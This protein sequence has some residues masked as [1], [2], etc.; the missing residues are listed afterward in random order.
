MLVYGKIETTHDA[1]AL[2][3][4][5]VATLEAL[6]DAPSG[7]DR[8]ARLAGAFVDAAALTCA[9]IDRDGMSDMAPL[10][11]LARALDASWRSEAHD[12][13][14]AIAGF[15]ALPATGMI[16]LKPTEGY[17]FYALYPES[18]AE[19]ARRA[20]LPPT[21]RVIGIRSIGTGLA[22]IV[23]AALGAEA[24]L[25]VRPTGHP[26]DRRIEP[27]PELLAGDPPAFAIVDEGPGLSGSSFLSV[28][29]WLMD[30][31]VPCTRIH[32]FPSHHNGPGAEAGVDR[33]KLWRQL[34]QH[35][36]DFAP[37][38]T[39]LP[40]WI[41]TRIGPLTA[42]LR[43]LSGGQWREVTGSIA[44]TAPGAE[45]RKYLAETASGGWMVKFA[46]IG[47]TG[48][49]KLALAQNVSAAGLAPEPAGLA[50]GFLIQRWVDAP[51][52]TQAPLP[53]C[54]LIT[55]LAAY[56]AHRA[57]LT[58]PAD[59]GARPDALAKMAA[60]NTAE[61]LGETAANAMRHR[62]ELNRPSGSPRR[63]WVDARLHPW[64]WLN[65]DGRLIKADALDHAMAHDFIGAQ[66]IEWDLA[67]AI[68]EHDLAPE[69]LLTAYEAAAGPAVDPSLLD[70][71]TGCYL[72]FQLGLWTML[73][74]GPAPATRYREKL[75]VWLG[76]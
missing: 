18:Y 13:R 31:G 36:A 54:R 29:T 25:T 52:L 58:A 42:P 7:L 60:Y 44:P 9:I 10:T 6:C 37:I 30:R 50:H 72:S 38:A 46:G 4:E 64:E 24:P 63:V 62:L 14:P 43:D 74:S 35:V 28:A 1:A 40:G 5:V 71:L 17:A 26:F 15:A 68:I 67:G 34:P 73:G 45:R 21:T 39:R 8:H 57:T 51:N 16:R 49:R 69:P 22:A 2:H 3:A 59:A 76:R 55:Q 19:A 48:H 11:A 47:A 65:A 75:S 20:G 33:L 56:L 66:P 32:L 12:L 23:A 41:A 70:F 61:G 27:G 53:Q